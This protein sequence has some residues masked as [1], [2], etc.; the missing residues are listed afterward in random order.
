MFLFLADRFEFK[1]PFYCPHNL[2]PVQKYLLNESM[3]E[4][5]VDITYFGQGPHIFTMNFL[6]FL[7]SIHNPWFADK[8]LPHQIPPSYPVI[9]PTRVNSDTPACR[10]CI[11]I[12]RS[13]QVHHVNTAMPSHLLVA[14]P[15]NPPASTS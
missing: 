7:P 13:P 3:Y 6:P 1:S 5:I 10:L 4:Q 14:F 12:S 15:E 2:A 9:P 11:S 8:T